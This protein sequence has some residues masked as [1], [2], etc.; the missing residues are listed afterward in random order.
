M[1]IHDLNATFFVSIDGDSAVSHHSH[2]GSI[3]SSLLEKSDY[4][5]IGALL[6]FC[7]VCVCIFVGAMISLSHFGP[8]CISFIRTGSTT[9]NSVRICA[10]HS[11]ASVIVCVSL[12]CL[13][14]YQQ[15]GHSNRFY[16]V[17]VGVCIN[18]SVFLVTSC[19][20]VCSASLFYFQFEAKFHVCSVE[21]CAIGY[22]SHEVCRSVY[23]GAPCACVLKHNK[24]IYISY[25]YRSLRLF[26][27]CETRKRFL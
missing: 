18:F 19:V 1:W 6:L 25:S 2:S 23:H 17:S 24:S 16:S 26:A 11:Y 3:M 14:T 20:Y 13:Y 21:M 7:C 9:A 27:L 15:I 22:E 10:P 4:N 12:L 8:L 5:S